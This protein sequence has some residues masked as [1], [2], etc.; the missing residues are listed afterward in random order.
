[1]AY[2]DDID[3]LSPDHRWS[4]DNTYNDQV[5]TVNG[6]GS[7]WDFITTPLCRDVIYSG[8]TNGTSDRVSIPTTTNI[9]N[10]AQTRKAVAG[11]FL[12]TAYNA[13]PKRIY[14]E[15]NNA[16][17]FQFV[18]AYGNNVMFECVEPTN[19]DIQVF[20]PP[21][22]PNRAY[23][24]CGIFEG[25]DYGNEVRFYVDG[26]KM[27]LSAP[28]NPAPGTVDLNSRDV[29][30]FGDPAGTVGIGGDVVLLN[31]PINGLYNEWATW[32]GA[33]AVL[34]D[35][36]VRETLFEKGAL[37]DITISS[38]TE[39]NMQTAL[40]AYADTVRSDA[41]LCIRINDVT[42][43]GDLALTADNITFDPLASIHIQWIGTG[44][45]TWTNTNGAN[46]SIGSTPNSGTILFVKDVTV[47]ITVKDVS[48][49][50]VIQNARVLLEADSGGDLTAGDDILSDLT[51]SNG[52]VTTTFGY[53]ND[54]PYTVKVRKGTNTPYYIEA[55]SAGT[56]T[57]SGLDII[58]LL[59]KDS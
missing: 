46:A 59:I 45:L 7:G 36:E 50:S 29:G 52:E 13:P 18:M 47:K 9:N 33:N 53:T 39:S 21:M 34:T 41:P 12:T 3:S 17:S 30:E 51:D 15:G 38:D 14:G 54:Q 32:D 48:D 1:M 58:I 6:T 20:G 43:S 27:D 35:T 40:D 55:I 28:T 24:L 19:F 31:A 2:S 5:G 42:G 8:R 37:P 26:V 56:I 57:S 16:T 44:T 10:S 11:W 22:K 23:H 25:S 49:N 4:F